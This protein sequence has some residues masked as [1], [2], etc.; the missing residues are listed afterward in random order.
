MALCAVVVML[1]A[2]GAAAGDFAAGLDVG[3]QAGFG[4]HLNGTFRD[5]AR[6]VPLS[7]RFV[8]G[9]HSA[10][11]GDPYAARR[12]FIND[13]TNGTP[14]DKAKYWQFRFDLLF[15]L[16]TLG[17]QQINVCLGP[18][19]ANYTAEFVYVGG[20]EDFEVRSDGWGAGLGLETNF[21]ISTRTDFVIKLGLDHFL[22]SDLA[23]HDT[24]YSPDGTHINPR[25]GYDYDSADEAVDQPKTEILIM[26]GLLVGL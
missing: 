22:K 14:E 7:A 26:V 15:P 21:A 20:N 19:Y 23:G 4:V 16:M 9:V 3:T 13:N 1:G 2:G 11:A 12:V 25:D 24:T 6:D 10:S 5:F 17:G 8:M 18:R